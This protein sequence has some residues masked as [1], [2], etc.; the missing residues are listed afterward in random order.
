MATAAPG[1]RTRSV[2]SVGT[3]RPGAVARKEPRM[4]TNYEPTPEQV[5]RMRHEMNLNVAPGWW[6]SEGLA[7]FILTRQHAREKGLLEALR[8]VA[9][10]T[11]AQPRDECFALNRK[12]AKDALAAHAALD[13]APE[14]TL[15]DAV[16]QIE[17]ACPGNIIAMLKDSQAWTVI[18]M[19]AE[20]ERAK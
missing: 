11:C 14:P 3:T 2:E 7:C 15:A 8:F 10:H 1:V 18:K 13:A 5:E 12:W 16:D 17:R 19:R 20:K 9:E 6:N 4:S